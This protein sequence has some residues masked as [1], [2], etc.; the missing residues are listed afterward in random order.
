MVKKEFDDAGPGKT[1][2]VLSAKLMNKPAWLDPAILN[3]IF[4]ETQTFAA[5]DQAT[6]DRLLNPLDHDVLQ[7]IAGELHGN[8]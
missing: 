2:I 3:Q 4:A 7:E 8:R 6:Y 5:R 1:K